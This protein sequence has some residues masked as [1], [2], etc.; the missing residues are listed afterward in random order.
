[1]NNGERRISK[2]TAIIMVSIIAFLEL[3][4]ILLNF[5]PGPGWIVIWLMDVLIWLTYFLWFK[6][7]GVGF[8]SKRALNLGGSFLIEMIPI[9]DALPG[10]TLAV[11]LMIRSS[12]K[13]DALNSLNAKN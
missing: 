5:L 11:I 12:W 4:Q 3:I 10:W 9:I 8:S 7:K 6:I 13:E 1:M 2:P